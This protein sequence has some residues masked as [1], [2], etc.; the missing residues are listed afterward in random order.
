MEKENKIKTDGKGDRN[1]IARRALH[2]QDI[3]RR[4]QYITKKK[5]IEDVEKLIE[6]RAKMIVDFQAQIKAKVI[7]EKKKEG[8]PM[9]EKDMLSDVLSMTQTLKDMEITLI[10]H[11]E[12]IYNLTVNAG[13]S[14]KTMEAA[15]KKQYDEVNAFYDEN[16]KKA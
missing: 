11:K 3:Q 8:G 5:E 14:I 9:T 10:F 13:I 7:T 16:F 1:E 15:I 12:D 6:N 4:R 2:A